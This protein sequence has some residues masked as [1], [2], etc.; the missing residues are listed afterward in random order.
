MALSIG[1][2]LIK[3]SSG[4]FVIWQIFVLRSVIVIPCLLLFILLVTRQASRKPVAFWWVTIRS[5]LLV[6]MWISYYL[7]LPHLSLSVAAAAYYTLPIFITL[8]SAWLASENISRVSWLAVLLGFGGI[9][10]IMKPSTDE[11]NWYV[12]LPLLSAILYALA[13]I[14]TRTK[15]RTEQPLVLSLALNIMF[16]LVGVLAMFLINTLAIE[17][18]MA[19]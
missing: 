3:S 19:F 17:K 18:M 1:D 9:L 15:C 16:I 5:M 8:L 12:L 6:A 10:L 7:S 11:F 14:L 2:A 13:M 4:N